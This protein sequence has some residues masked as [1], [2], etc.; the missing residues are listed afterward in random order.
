MF[1]QD[2]Q[3]RERAVQERVIRSAAKRPA[4]DRKVTET[5]WDKVRTRLKSSG[6]TDSDLEIMDTETVEASKHSLYCAITIA[7]YREIGRLPQRESA[8]LMRSLFE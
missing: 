1:P 3:A 4:I 5:L 7:M 6:V 8:T 2:I